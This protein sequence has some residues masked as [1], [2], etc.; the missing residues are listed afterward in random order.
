MHDPPSN[1]DQ[2]K[3]IIMEELERQDSEE[4]EFSPISVL[5]DEV[6]C[7]NTRISQLETLI[8]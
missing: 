5:L 3:F 4:A 6:I 2:I 7:A 8:T 1:T